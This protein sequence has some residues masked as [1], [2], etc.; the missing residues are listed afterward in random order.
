MKNTPIKVEPGIFR[1]KNAFD[2]V[3]PWKSPMMM[4]CGNWSKHNYRSFTQLKKILMGYTPNSIRT[5]LY[6]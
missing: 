1:G 5:L 3:G 6:Y 4:N 2:H